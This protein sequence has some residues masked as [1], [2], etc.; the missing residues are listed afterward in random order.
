ME[1]DF[2]CRRWFPATSCNRK[3]IGAKYFSTGYE[4][5]NGK[6][7]EMLE[8]RSPRDLDGHGTDTASI[9]ASRYVFPAS[10][11]GYRK[12]QSLPVRS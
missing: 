12:I 7:I 5:T 6:M 9:P 8:H 11:L 4:A 10:T 2:R 1:G 3:L